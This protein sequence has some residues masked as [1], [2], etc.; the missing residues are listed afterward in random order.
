MSPAGCIMNGGIGEGSDGR[1]TRVVAGAIAR[2]EFLND[3]DRM[4]D[5]ILESDKHPEI[6]IQGRGRG[7]REYPE[8]PPLVEGTIILTHLDS[9]KYNRPVIREAVILVG[10]ADGNNEPEVEAL[11]RRVA[12]KMDEVRVK[13]R[14]RGCTVMDGRWVSSGGGGSGS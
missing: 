8:G 3:I 4:L 9:S 14:E 7:R 10:E 2:I 5:E 6:R 1:G 11:R 12:A 13:V